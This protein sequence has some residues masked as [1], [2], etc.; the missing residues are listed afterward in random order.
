M[1]P[2]TRRNRRFIIGG[3]LLAIGPETAR[4]FGIWLLAGAIL[5]LLGFEQKK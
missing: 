5:G 1:T 3:E 2:K 4:A